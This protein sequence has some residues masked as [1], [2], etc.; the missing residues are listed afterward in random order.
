[1][2]VTLWRNYKKINKNAKR[3]MLMV[4]L[5]IWM[6]ILI[7]IKIILI[8]MTTIL[9]IVWMIII[10]VKMILII[11]KL[12]LIIVLMMVIVVMMIML[13]MV[14]L[15]VNMNDHVGRKFITTIKHG[16]MCSANCN[17]NKTRIYGIS[18]LFYVRMYV[19]TYVV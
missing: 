4:I 9:I 7:I 14:L 15:D 13:M 8:I 18:F 11:V 2:T 5:L 6:I 16:T 19:C 12:I 10:I 3:T 17:D 1:M